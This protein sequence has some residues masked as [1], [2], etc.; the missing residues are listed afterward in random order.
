M[1]RPHGKTLPCRARILGYVPGK[2]PSSIREKEMNLK[3]HGQETKLLQD[4]VFSTQ[5]VISAATKGGGRGGESKL[6][7][8][9]LSRL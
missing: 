9:S 1:L 5:E 3:T 4:G 2:E 8:G 7:F 6:A